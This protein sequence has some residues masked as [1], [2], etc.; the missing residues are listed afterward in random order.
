MYKGET[1]SAI[2][3]FNELI[4]NFPTSDLTLT[5]RLWKAKALYNS[6]KDDDA[7]LTIDELLP[8]AE[9]NGEND[10]IIEALMLKGQIQIDREDYTYAV[11]VYEK[12]TN[13]SG[14]GALLAIAQYQLGLCQSRLGNYREAAEAFKK[15]EDYNPT[16]TKKYQ[17]QLRE[18]VML[19]ISGQH[20]KALEVLENLKGQ[21]LRLDEKGMVELEIANTYKRMSDTIIAF[22]MYDRIDS[23]YKKTD[24][25]AKS[26]YERGLS[27]END[28]KDYRR[29]LSFYEKAKSEFPSSEITPIAQKKFQYLTRYFKLN[30]DLIKFDSLLVVKT[31]ADL[32]GINN[33]SLQIA[34]DISKVENIIVNSENRALEDTNDL[35]T[36]VNSQEEDESYDIIDEDLEPLPEEHSLLEARTAHSPLVNKAMR[37]GEIEN[38]Q[39]GEN[40]E[41]ILAKG[42]SA[43]SLNGQKK[44]VTSGQYSKV[45][46]DS[47]KKLIS[48][49]K[50]ELGVLFLLDMNL[51]D[52]ALYVYQDLVEN[53][54]ESKYAPRAYYSMAEIYRERYDS[55]MVDSLY[56]IIL[57]KYEQ[58]EY[59]N[60]V[61][62]SL[63]IKIDNNSVEP[64]DSLYAEGEKLLNSG[65]VANA[66]KCFEDITIEYPS[67]PQAAKA[68]YALGW[69]QEVV[70]INNDSATSIYQKL[71][72]NY[73]NSIYT[74]EVKP[75]LAIKEDPKTVD[76]YIKI[77]EIQGIAKTVPPKKEQNNPG[78]LDQNKRSQEQ[79]MR[80]Q[81]PDEEPNQDEEEP[82]EEEPEDT[83]DGG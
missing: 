44:V 35:I 10:I 82:E 1:E 43:D 2:R 60:Q 8:D 40:A 69:I 7:I 24:A 21:A 34:E 16:V 11:D 65:D 30:D 72:K 73:P 41:T 29:A 50:F 83:D 63:G 17:A 76:K 19:S 74:A 54:P 79:L 58:T 39:S 9:K 36:E 81:S 15:V 49:T 28:Y 64:A 68:L 55:L 22:T 46:L 31:K 45:S 37:D 71:I 18:G 20:E 70:F 57:N 53:F 66:C 6:N 47:L 75:K 14:S 77:N 13:I 42:I 32:L 61:K 5:A 51:Y 33:D 12:A 38:M 80:N 48:Q 67:S 3:K 59:S 52:S 23:V 62:R 27:Y 25:A 78:E 4:E 26:Y 56:K